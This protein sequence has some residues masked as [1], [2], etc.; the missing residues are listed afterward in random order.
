M[1]KPLTGKQ[2]QDIVRNAIKPALNAIG[3][4]LQ[5]RVQS[6]APVD[7]GTLRGAVT[8][9]V[10]IDERTM[11]VTVR[12]STPYARRQHEE[13]TWKHPRGGKAKYMSD[14]L[15][16]NSARYRAIMAASIKR[17]IDNV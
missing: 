5:G 15:K 13:V 1:T 16:A 11:K 14:P 7:E 17:A 3:A 4:D 6:E 2:I 10:Q 12:A 8:Y 9:D